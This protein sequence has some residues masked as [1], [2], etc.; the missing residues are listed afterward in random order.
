[1]IVFALSHS[2][3]FPVSPVPLFS[4]FPK[5]TVELFN[6]LKL[7]EQMRNT[8]KRARALSVSLIP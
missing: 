3:V 6:P 7:T 1:M 2:I 4:G 8:P 5:K